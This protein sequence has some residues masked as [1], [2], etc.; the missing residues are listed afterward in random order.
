MLAVAIVISWAAFA[1]AQSPFDG[2]W[3]LNQEKSN[4]TGDTMSFSAAGSGTMKFSD[5]GQTYQFKTD[6]S[7][8]NT[9]IGESVTWKETGPNTYEHTVSVNGNLTSTENWKVSED[10]KTL[11]IDSHGTKQSGEQWQDS[12]TYE[13]VGRGK[14]LAGKWKSTKVSLGSPNTLSFSQTGPDSLKLEISAEKATWEGKMDGKD[15]PASGPTILKGVTLALSPTS[16][17]SFKM[18]T[19]IN[20]KPVDIGEYSVSGNT[21][22]VK[23]TNGQGKE[24]YKEVWEKKS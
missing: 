21:L 5:S 1:V 20:G 24:P 8:T 6:G 23:G 3:A 14:G 17:S 19:K 2:T 12:A 16:A 4:L 15:Y 10:G 11:I 22:T 9:P 13:R 18:V 7:Q